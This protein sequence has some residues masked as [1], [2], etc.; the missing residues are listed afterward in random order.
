MYLFELEFSFSSF[1]PPIHP[2]IPRSV[3]AGLYGSPT[4]NFLGNLHSIFHSGY[5]SLYSHQQCTRILFSPHPCQLLFCGFLILVILTG[6][7]WYLIVVLIFI[8]L[9]TSDVTH[10][11]MFH[12]FMLA[13]CMY[14][15]NNLFYQ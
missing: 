12:V 7:R 3:I 8:S 10:L 5:T 9:M 15:K 1:F 4:F 11:F 6:I 2:Q 13:I 14:S